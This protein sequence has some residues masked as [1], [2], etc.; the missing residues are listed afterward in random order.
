MVFRHR[1]LPG[2]PPG[3][4]HPE[5]VRQ[6]LPGDRRGTP[7]AS[8]PIRLQTGQQLLPGRS[9]RGRVR[10]LTLSD[11]ALPR[12]VVPAVAAVLVALALAGRLADPQSPP[13]GLYPDEGAEAL[14]AYPVVHLPR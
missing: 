7:A 5:R 14:D 2:W 9:L 6:D 11:R 1:R 3:A 4:R 10:P 12:W 8:H 13:G